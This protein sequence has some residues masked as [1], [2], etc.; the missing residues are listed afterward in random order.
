MKI[1][2]FSDSHGVIAPMKE[3]VNKGNPDMVLHLG[4]FNRDGWWLAEMFPNIPHHFV[5]GNC[6]PRLSLKAESEEENTLVV[7]GKRIF[8]THGHRYDV[9]SSYGPIRKAGLNAGVDVVLFG[10]THVA[11]HE[12]L[13]AMHILNPGSP[14]MAAQHTYGEIWIVD[15]TVQCAIVEIPRKRRLFGG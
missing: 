13:G 15:E 10:H 9:K 11:H 2:V 1:F 8:M 6:D 14:S 5:R 7:S 3:V 12:L 4:D